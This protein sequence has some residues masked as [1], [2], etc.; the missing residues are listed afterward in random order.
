LERRDAKTRALFMFFVLT[1]LF[2]L[3]FLKIVLAISH[4]PTTD[5]RSK[6][7][8]DAQIAFLQQ[9]LYLENSRVYK[10]AHAMWDSVQSHSN[11]NLSG[12]L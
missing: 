1:W 4:L 5:S 10:I 2:V 7:I 12:Q 3:L 11:T 8:F 9:I 6:F